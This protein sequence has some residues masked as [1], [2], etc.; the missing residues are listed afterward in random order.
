M[1]LVVTRTGNIIYVNAARLLQVTIHLNLGY[2]CSL[3]SADSAAIVNATYTPVINLCFDH[4]IDLRDKVY[5]LVE[6]IKQGQEKFWEALPLRIALG[7]TFH[8]NIQHH[9][10]VRVDKPNTSY[11]SVGLDGYKVIEA[12]ALDAYCKDMAQPFPVQK[13]APNIHDL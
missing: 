3:C 11:L 4:L 10:N 7:E 9:N 2:T 13:G 1:G 12:S 6:V 5:T 8:M